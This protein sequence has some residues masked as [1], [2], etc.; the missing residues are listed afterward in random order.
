MAISRGTGLK[1]WDVGETLN[2]YVGKVLGGRRLK[3]SESAQ[4]HFATVLTNV[5]H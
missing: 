5:N 4:L 3:F 1:P 2:N